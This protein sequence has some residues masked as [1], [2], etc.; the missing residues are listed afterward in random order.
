MSTRLQLL[1]DGSESSDSAVIHAVKMAEGYDASIVPTQVIDTRWFKTPD[2]IADVRYV[3]EQSLDRV[4]HTANRHG[5]TISDDK[6]VIARSPARE[7]LKEAKT[8][9]PS[10]IVMGAYDHSIRRVGLS[11]LATRILNSARC[12]VLLAK[13]G[14]DYKSAFENVL[15][16]TNTLVDAGFAVEFAKR[17]NSPLTACHCVDLEEGILKERIV[18]LPEA[19]APGV[20]GRERRRLGER[21]RTS[22]TLLDRMKQ[23]RIEQGYAVVDQVVDLARERGVDAMAVVRDGRPETELAKLTRNEDFGLLIMRHEYRN[24]IT[25]LIFGTMPMKIARMVSCPVLAVK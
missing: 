16:S 22:Q 3:L 5:V 15:V 21:V 20:S 6:T 24:L 1:I 11:D 18:Y 2:V 10:S 14:V 8:I 4:Y 13:N 25:R 23:R 9:D 19:A 7:V 17:F 12:D